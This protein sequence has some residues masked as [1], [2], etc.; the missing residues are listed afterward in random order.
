MTPADP[1]V[2]VDGVISLFGSSRI[3]SRIAS[4]LRKFELVDGV[5]H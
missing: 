3:A 4:H 5:P 2:D 1:R